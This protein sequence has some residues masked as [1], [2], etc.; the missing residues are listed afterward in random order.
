MSFWNYQKNHCPNQETYRNVR[1]LLDAV[2]RCI[3][4]RGESFFLKQT[5]GLIS[6]QGQ[7]DDCSGI[8]PLIGTINIQFLCY[9]HVTIQNKRRYCNKHILLDI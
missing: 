2:Y 8:L 9:N 7:T 5:H 4:G 3:E 1:Q 6:K